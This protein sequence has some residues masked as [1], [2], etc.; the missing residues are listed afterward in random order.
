ME[1]TT[2]NI[3]NHE[4]HVQPSQFI[5]IHLESI[6]GN[7]SSSCWLWFAQR[8]P[9]LPPWIRDFCSF[10]AI[11]VR[12]GFSGMTGFRVLYVLI[13]FPT[14]I[15]DH[16]HECYLCPRGSSRSY[17]GIHQLEYEL[18]EH[19]DILLPTLNQIP[20]TNGQFFFSTLSE[21]MGIIQAMILLVDH[22]ARNTNQVFLL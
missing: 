2:S 3:F 21:V 8:H 9:N 6:K 19:L 15:K 7:R 14:L 11:E 18:P 22:S 12:H 4:L 13:W 5:S 20:K 1:K 10:V 16:G 17:S